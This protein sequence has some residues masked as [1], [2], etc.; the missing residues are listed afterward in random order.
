[1]ITRV[2]GN[3]RATTITDTLTITL[4]SAPLNGNFLVLCTQCVHNSLPVPTIV[5][6]AQTGVTW[7][8]QKPKSLDTGWGG[9][10]IEIWAGVVG[11]GASDTIVATFSGAGF[12]GIIGD[13]CEYSGV[14]SLDFLDQTASDAN[15]TTEPPKS[16]TTPMTAQNDELWVACFGTNT[17]QINP[18]NGFTLFDGAT[19]HH[20]VNGGTIGLT[21]LDKIVSSIDTA[22]VSSLEDSAG[23]WAGAITTYRS[24]IMASIL[25]DGLTIPNGVLS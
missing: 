15:N 21:Y 25:T 13:A 22:S 18:T 6:I 5:S 14:I 24:T 12:F 10:T 19:Y 1:M 17:D 2:Q 9:E 8:Q 11:A 3:A 20:P 7:T 16:G 4:T 23:W